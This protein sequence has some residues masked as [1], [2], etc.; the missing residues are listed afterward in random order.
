MKTVYKNRGYLNPIYVNGITQ[1]PYLHNK[2][3]L[4]LDTD[5]FLTCNVEDARNKGIEATEEETK[6]YYI[7]R[8]MCKL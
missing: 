1:W 8:K 6:Y 2:D 5:T 4:W 7:M 3:Y